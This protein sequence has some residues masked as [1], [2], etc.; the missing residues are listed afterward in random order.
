MQTHST[1]S[2]MSRQRDAIDLHVSRSIE[3]FVSSRASRTGFD[4]VFRGN[5]AA[6]TPVLV[7]TNTRV[8]LRQSRAMP[9]DRCPAKQ[10]GHSLSATNTERRDSQ[11]SF[12]AG[13]LQPVVQRHHQPQS[14]GS[15]WMA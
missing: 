11:C 2:D 10:N 12:F 15:E 6:G 14:A 9:L 7:T 5:D 1:Y 13:H 4:A 3:I 8:V